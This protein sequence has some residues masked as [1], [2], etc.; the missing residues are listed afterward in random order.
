MAYTADQIAA[1]EAALL[2]PELTIE[3]QGRKVTYRS[4]ADIEGALAY[5]RQQQAEA[6]G[7]PSYSL[8]ATSRD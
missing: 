8:V 1:A 5:A 4:R 2:A 3:Y 7:A 6:A